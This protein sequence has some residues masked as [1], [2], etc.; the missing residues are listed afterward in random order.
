MTACGVAHLAL[1]AHQLVNEFMGGSIADLD[2]NVKQ[3]IRHIK[4]SLGSD[5]VGIGMLSC[6]VCRHRSILFKVLADAC[7][8]PSRLVRGFSSTGFIVGT[9]AWNVVRASHRG[10]EG[11]VEYSYHIVD[12]MRPSGALLVLYIA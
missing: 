12:V 7:D 4:K 9:H 5:I 1:S 11:L 3:N 10:R 2:L 8:V 6:G